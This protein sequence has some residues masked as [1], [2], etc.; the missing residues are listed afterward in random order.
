MSYNNVP[1]ADNTV[2]T[3]ECKSAAMVDTMQNTRALSADALAM[4]RRIGRFLFG[5]DDATCEKMADPQCFQDELMLTRHNLNNVC[6]LLS[7]IMNMLGT[8]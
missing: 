6:E 3:C 5:T 4:T 1:C 2:G 7:E 8:I